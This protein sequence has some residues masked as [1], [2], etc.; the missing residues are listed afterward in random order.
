[1]LSQI[2]NRLAVKEI[3]GKWYPENEKRKDPE[4]V[5]ASGI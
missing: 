3:S 4:K 5:V 2:F 1:V